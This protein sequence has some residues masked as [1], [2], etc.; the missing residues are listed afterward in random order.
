LAPQRGETFAPLDR[1]WLSEAIDSLRE[2]DVKTQYLLAVAAAALLS[3][4]TAF[5]EVSPQRLS[6]ITRTLGSDAFEGR[7]PATRAEEKTVAYIIEQF[8]A[9][10]VQP[11][12]EVVNGRRT[13]TQNVP[14]LKSDITG[15]PTF[16]LNLG[17]G[18][19]LSLTQGEEI[20]VKAPLNGQKQISLNDVPLVFVGYGVTAPER[21]WDDFK[22]VDVKGKLI[23]L[24]VN[25]PDFEGG[26][27][28]F[29]GKAMTY[30]GRWTYKYEEA[31]RRGA[32]GTLVIHETEPASYGWAT[33]K[34]SNTNTQFDVVADNPA[35]AHA[36]VEAW[37]QRDLADRIFKA[38]GMTFDQAKA[39][40]KT[41]AFR[42][43]ELKARMDL[44]FNAATEVIISKNVVGLLPGTKYPDET[45]L[46]TGHWDHLGIGKP[47][48]T[49]DTIYNGALDNATGIAQIIEQARWFAKEPRTDRS[50]VF[51]AVTAEEKGLLG[52]EYYASHP[53]YPIGKT[54][55]V[56][57]TDGG[58]LWGR[59]KNFTISGNARLGLL[60]LLIAEGRKQ[61]RYYSP[62]PHPEAGYFFRSDHFAFAKAGVPAISFN[63]GND[64]VNGGTARGE[65]LGKVYNEKSYHQPSDEWS[66][67]WDFTGMAEDV[68]LLHNVGRILANSRLWPEWSADSE[69]KAE[70]DKTAAERARGTPLPPAPA[71]APPAEPAAP[72]KGERG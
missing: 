30:Y 29:G 35:A 55:G 13:W 3:T 12:G 40:A 69:F 51:L 47:D 59:A 28:D 49:G 4:T 52:S 44:N 42:P 5:A 1:P 10:G 9:A 8:K 34:N 58:Q 43:V 54:V 72:G 60:D 57:N 26:E 22:D 27:G 62:D 45:I 15:T 21:N 68:V 70:R 66:P 23:V 46:Y 19:P 24:F 6:D 67:E 31:A 7:G 32:A 20:S 71:A 11:G 25:D 64:L 39:M 41:R 2:S 65:A 63:E 36:P 61:G 50:I 18:Q 16:R 38:S 33:V 48:E 14:L 17:S 53:L 56:L 37:I